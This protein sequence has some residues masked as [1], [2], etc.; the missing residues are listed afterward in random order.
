MADW[1]LVARFYLGAESVAALLRL[2]IC[3]MMQSQ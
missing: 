2:G 3:D 1:S